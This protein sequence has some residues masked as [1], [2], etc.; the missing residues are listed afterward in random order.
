MWQKFTLKPSALRHCLWASIKVWHCTDS[1]PWVATHSSLTFCKHGN[2]R[3][4]GELD[5]KRIQQGK[6]TNFKTDH[7]SILTFV[8]GQAQQIFLVGFFCSTSFFPENQEKRPMPITY[9]KMKCGGRDGPIS[10]ELNTE[11]ALLKISQT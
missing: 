10:E 9:L 1:G 6:A 4:L 8:S 11:H 5:R 7:N 3:T 2:I